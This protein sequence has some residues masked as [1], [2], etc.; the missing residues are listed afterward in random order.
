[1]YQQ[2]KQGTAFIVLVIGIELGALQWIE[3]TMNVYGAKQ[4]GR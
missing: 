3:I 2:G 4:Q 1:M